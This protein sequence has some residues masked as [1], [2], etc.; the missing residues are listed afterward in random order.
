MPSF[1]FFLFKNLFKGGSLDTI[2]FYQHIYF[3]LVN[4][5][6]FFLYVFKDLLLVLLQVDSQGKL[7]PEVEDLLLGIADDFIDS[8]I[9]LI[10]SVFLSI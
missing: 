8:V 2:F 6:F 4:F 3:S 1:I 10:H 5:F 7:D 9:L